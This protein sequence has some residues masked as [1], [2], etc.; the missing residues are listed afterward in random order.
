MTDD[1][2]KAEAMLEK[3]KGQTR[4]DSE[5]ITDNSGEPTTLETAIYHAYQDIDAGNAYTNL[6]IRDENLAALFIGLDETNELEGIAKDAAD[7][8]DRDVDGDVT[9]TLALGLLVRAGLENVSAETLETA[10]DARR[11][12]LVDQADDI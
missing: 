5:P 3:S 12:F 7:Q 9:R 10:K 6:T 2:A 8:L 4:K 11:S 1:K